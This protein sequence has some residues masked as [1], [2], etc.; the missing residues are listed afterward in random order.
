MY[1]KSKKTRV[2]YLVYTWFL[3]KYTYYD[4][5][6]VYP[7]I[8]WDLVITEHKQKE[9]LLSIQLYTLLKSVDWDTTSEAKYALHILQS[10]PILKTGGRFFRITS[11]SKIVAKNLLLKLRNSQFKIV[12][13]FQFQA[14]FTKVFPK[15]WF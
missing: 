13:I 15:K 3:Y 14:Y 6:V 2:L 1:K 8:Y 5:A 10:V 12:I 11:I 9:I 4:A 7:V